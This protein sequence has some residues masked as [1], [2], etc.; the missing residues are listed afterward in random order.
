MHTVFSDG[1]VWP[2]VRVDEAWREGLDAIAI[3]DH[4]EYQPHKDDLPTKHARPYEIAAAKAKDLNIL[5]VR[6][7]E[8][9]R[10]TP[11]GHYN[12]LFVKDIAALDIKDFL[13]QIK[14]ANEQGA[15][16]FWNHPGWKQK[17]DESYWFDIHTQLFNEK[18]VQGIEFINGDRIFSRRP[19]VGPGTQPDLHGQFGHAFA[20][21]SA[22]GKPRQS[23][24][25][26]AGVRQG[27]LAGRHSG[28]PQV[29]PHGHLGRGQALRPGRIPQAPVRGV[30]GVLP[31]L[32]PQRHDGHRWRSATSRMCPSNWAARETPRR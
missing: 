29:R 17:G 27:P 5:L 31:R 26:D 11:P 14:A 10:D 4:I 16:V 3:T 6:A 32:S 9:T 28:G 13:T 25:D 19:Q 1:N 12:A 23:P 2:T 20:D 24:H 30:G 21:G 7:A 8:I 15:F 22:D 18:L